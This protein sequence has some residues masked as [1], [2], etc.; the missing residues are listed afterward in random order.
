MQ[1]SNPHTQTVKSTTYILVDLLMTL[2]IMLLDMLELRRLPEGRHI[3]I[4]FP[5]PLMQRRIP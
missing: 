4:Q 2:R 1:I 5:Q 3:P